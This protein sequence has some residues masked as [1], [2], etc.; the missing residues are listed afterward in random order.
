VLDTEIDLSWTAPDFDG[1]SAIT[2]Y[3]IE[4]KVGVG[5]FTTLTADTGN[6]QTTYSDT[7]LTP[8]TLYTYRVSAI[9]GSG[10]SATSSEASD[11][12]DPTP[13]ADDEEE[14][15]NDP[16]GSNKRDT[17]LPGEDDSMEEETISDEVPTTPQ[18]SE[19]IQQAIEHIQNTLRALIEEVIRILFAEVERLQALQP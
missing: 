7:G 9:N 18:T 14:N 10:T 13:V 4:R 11:T 5:A 2:G 8:E 12:T 3:F 19:E 6:N 15:N 1:N 16:S 17:P